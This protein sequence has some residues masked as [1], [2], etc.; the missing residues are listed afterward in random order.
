MT[1]DKMIKRA[2]D[3]YDSLCEMLET[4]NWKFERIPSANIVTFKTVGEDLPMD[5]IIKVDA[6]KQLVRLLS[7]ISFEFPEDKRME[8]A[9]VTSF[10]NYNLADGS[11]DYD[12]KTGKTVFR[13]TTSFIDS[14]ISSELLHFMVGCACYTLDEY[15]DKFFMVSKGMLSLDDFIKNYA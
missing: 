7:P 2:T 13:M 4:N 9:V 5:F 11:F 1:D 8:G 12:V 10:A 3:V 14:L 6:E 15:N